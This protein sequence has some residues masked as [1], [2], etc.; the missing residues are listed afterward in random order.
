[1]PQAYQQ[2]LD[3]F[4]KSKGLLGQ[5]A[6]EPISPPA[7]QPTQD[8]QKDLDDFLWSKGAIELGG[9]RKETPETEFKPPVTGQESVEQY[10][11]EPGF[12]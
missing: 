1:M 3:E 11:E 8:L 7:T 4:L 6:P 5:P 9:L 10:M 12:W 2:E